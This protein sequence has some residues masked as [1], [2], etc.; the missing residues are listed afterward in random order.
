MSRRRRKLLSGSGAVGIIGGSNLTDLATFTRASSATLRTSA[1]VISEVGENIPRFSYSST[2]LSRKYLGE[3]QRQNEA[4][5]SETFDTAWW[6][7]DNITA[8]ANSTT[9]PDGT[10]NAYRFLEVANLNTHRI[11]KEIFKTLTSGLSYS[12]SVFVKPIDRDYF[13]IQPVGA[14]F[15][16]TFSSF[17]FSTETATAG[18][19]ATNCAMVDYGNGW[20]RLTVTYTASASASGGFRLGISNNGSNSDYLGDITK[21]AYI[22]GGQFETAVFPSTYIPTTTAAVTRSPDVLT[23]ENLDT[24]PSF[25]A[26]EGTV[27][28][29]FT[30]TGWTNNFQTILAL[31][32]G[33]TNNGIY[34][35]VRGSGSQILE[36][37]TFISTVQ[38]VGIEL[39]NPSSANTRYRVSFRYR[40]NDYAVSIN[41][42]V[43]VTDTSSG[44]PVFDSLYV[45]D[46]GAGTRF[47]FSEYSELTYYPYAATDAQLQAMSAI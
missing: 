35:R 2:Y 1:S 29:D 22:W 36:L 42:G 45:G 47:T 30:Y 39:A 14:G 32:S 28:V 12:A 15:S 27:V 20:H 34:V 13:Y 7:Q 43:A 41:G 26:S 17:Q 33:A 24:Q 40:L 8:T 5:Y 37:A 38:T 9:S 11:R 31:G 3:G 10:V 25:N 4:L 19:G 44:V 21:G 23:V 6:A 46:A 18:T 16:G